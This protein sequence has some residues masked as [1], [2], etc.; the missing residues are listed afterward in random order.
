M[1]VGS[2]ENSFS[3]RSKIATTQTQCSTSRFVTE[4]IEIESGTDSMSLKKLL[5]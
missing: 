5:A 4:K 2:A 1:M 3:P